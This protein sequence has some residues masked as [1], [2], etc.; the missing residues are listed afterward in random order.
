MQ[1]VLDNGYILNKELQNFYNERPIIIP[2]DFVDF[3]RNVGNDGTATFIP[4]TRD[5]ISLNEEVVSPL[6]LMMLLN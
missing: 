1:F 3:L 6:F 2:P 5:N 4:E